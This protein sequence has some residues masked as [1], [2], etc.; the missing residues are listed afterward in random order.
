LGDFSVD[1]CRRA[2]EAHRERAGDKL[3]LEEEA[4]LSAMRRRLEAGS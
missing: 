2:L 3:T 4:V 1:T